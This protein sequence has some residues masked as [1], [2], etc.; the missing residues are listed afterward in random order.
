M[1]DDPIRK[2]SDERLQELVKECIGHPGI[3]HK[4]ALAEVMSEIERREKE[5]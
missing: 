3:G 1:E 4:I 2:L 5:K